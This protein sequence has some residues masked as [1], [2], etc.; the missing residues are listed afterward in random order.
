MEFLEALDRR[1]LRELGLQRRARPVDDGQIGHAGIRKRI[2]GRR[3]AICSASSATNEPHQLHVGELRKVLASSFGPDRP[4]DSPCSA[5][6]RAPANRS[7]RSARRPRRQTPWHP[8]RWVVRR[9]NSGCRRESA[10][11]P[12][13]HGWPSRWSRSRSVARCR[14]RAGCGE[15]GA[16][17]PLG[18][19][20]DDGRGALEEILGAT[21][22]IGL[23]EPAPVDQDPVEMILE[24]LLG[25][26]PDAALTRD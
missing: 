8:R 7:A 13:C 3:S 6:C 10:P 9:G 22:E 21:L 26:P 24:H 25:R 2:R 20:P 12:R 14:G 18:Q 15:S 19:R 16:H 17:E 23:V 4:R 5:S 11:A 1:Q